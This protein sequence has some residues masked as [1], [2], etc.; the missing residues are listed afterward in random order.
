MKTEE[1]EV[2]GR[3]VVVEVVGSLCVQGRL[4]LRYTQ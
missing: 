4:T 2:A 3:G 1:Y